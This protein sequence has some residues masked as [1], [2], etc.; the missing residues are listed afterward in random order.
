MENQ[1]VKKSEMKIK[2][3]TKP[4]SN[5]EKCF[6]ELKEKSYD[7]DWIVTINKKEQDIN[8]TGKSSTIHC[9]FRIFEIASKYDLLSFIASREVATVVLYPL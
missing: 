8:V 2:K 7:F 9:A 3:V 4:K 6:D 1:E 5:I